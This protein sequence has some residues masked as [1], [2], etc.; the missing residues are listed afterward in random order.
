MTDIHR[1]ICAVYGQDI[2]SDRMV[3]KWDRAFKNS[4]TNVHG[5]EWRELSLVIT[6][7]LV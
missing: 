2:M 5:D 7:D 3:K 6:D 1:K 4:Y